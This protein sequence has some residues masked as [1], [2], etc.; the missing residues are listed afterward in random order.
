M[1]RLTRD[2]IR[3]LKDLPSEVVIVPEWGG[4]EVEIRGLSGKGRDQFEIWLQVQKGKKIV[5]DATNVRAKLVVLCAVNEQGERVFTEGD[6]EWL[7]E[8]SGS[9][10]DRLAMAAMRLSGM[11]EEMVKGLEKN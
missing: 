3:G 11:S 9:A 1:A 10:L 5:M 2:E 8:K 4:T 6:I 7:G